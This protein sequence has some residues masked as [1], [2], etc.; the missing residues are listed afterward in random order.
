MIVFLKLNNILTNISSTKILSK[1]K[2]SYYITME[3]YSSEMGRGF[4]QVLGKKIMIM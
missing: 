4:H 2:I 1:L 3:N